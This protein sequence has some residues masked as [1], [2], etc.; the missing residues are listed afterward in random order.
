MPLIIGGGLLLGGALGYAGSQSA[1]RAQE[2][3]AKRSAAAQ[4]ESTQMNIDFQKWLWGEQKAI[5]QPY[6]DAGAEGL[7]GYQDAINTPFTKENMELDPGYD[8]RLS[9]GMKGIE[10]SASAKGMQLSGR[11]LKGLGRYAQD[12]ASG[13]FQNAYNRR[14]QGISNLYNLAA[15][16]Q[17]SASGQAVQGG[18]MGSQVSNSI[19]QGGQAQAQMY[20]DLGNINAAS[21]MAQSNSV[22]Q[23][24]GLAAQAYGAGAFS[25]GG[26]GYTTDYSIPM[27]STSF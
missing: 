1:G 23:V 24:G 10:N 14:Q 11:T 8:F 7:K 3:G 22:I 6:V 26:G 20:S 21:A 18:N 27:T 13:E 12:Y 4:T 15:M 19:L 17:A 16:G 2:S 9:E 5:T 25:G